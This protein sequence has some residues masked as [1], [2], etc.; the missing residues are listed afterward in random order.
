VTYFGC[1]RQCVAVSSLSGVEM[2]GLVE[3][4][5]ERMGRGKVKT[6]SEQT[7]SEAVPLFV[8]LRMEEMPVC[9]HV[10]RS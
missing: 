3:C 8:C 7:S 5:Q 2:A 4:V 6:V 10:E 9:R 1:S